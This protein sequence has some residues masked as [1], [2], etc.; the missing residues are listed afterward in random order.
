MKKLKLKY[1]IIDYIYRERQNG[2]YSGVYLKSL[3][4]SIKLPLEAWDELYTLFHN[5]EGDVMF[6]INKIY[7]V[8]PKNKGKYY[9]QVTILSSKIN[10]VLDLGQGRDAK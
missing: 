3:D 5:L 8:N 4:Y 7:L 10:E 2:P 9:T 6:T 1:W